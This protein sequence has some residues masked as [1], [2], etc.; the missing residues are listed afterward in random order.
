MVGESDLVILL[1]GFGKATDNIIQWDLS[2]SVGKSCLTEV[3]D[4]LMGTAQQETVLSSRTKFVS[5]LGT[6]GA[7]YFKLK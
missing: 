4:G 7:S 3:S 5:D 2:L 1:E 6:K